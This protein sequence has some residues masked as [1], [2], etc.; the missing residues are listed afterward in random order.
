M[1]QM[2]KIKRGSTTEKE[3]QDESAKQEPNSTEKT[4]QDKVFRR[5]T[6]HTYGKSMQNRTRHDQVKSQRKN[7]NQSAIHDAKGNGQR[8]KHGQRKCQEQKH[9]AK[10]ELARSTKSKTTMERR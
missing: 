6:N 8:C 10:V 2:W 1:R 3:E 4:M 9:A 5:G 7:T